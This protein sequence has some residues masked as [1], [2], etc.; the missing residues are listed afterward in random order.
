MPPTTIDYLY[1]L[2]LYAWYVKQNKIPSFATGN[3][4]LEGFRPASHK[5]KKPSLPSK[6]N[7]K[8]ENAARQ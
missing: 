6:K 4:F 8:T 5:A 2:V 7:I 1:V 3:Q